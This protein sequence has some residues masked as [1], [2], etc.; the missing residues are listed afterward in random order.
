MNLIAKLKPHEQ[1]MHINV[2]I[3]GTQESSFVQVVPIERR[4]SERES[5]VVTLNIHNLNNAVAQF[6]SVWLPH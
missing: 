3:D 2:F 5:S 1:T 4:S 6:D